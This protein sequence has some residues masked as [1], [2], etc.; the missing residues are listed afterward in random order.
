ML[1]QRISF[2]KFC[3]NDFIVPKVFMSAQSRKDFEAI[4]TYNKL[5]KKPIVADPT[6]SQSELKR[7]KNYFERVLEYRKRSEEGFKPSKLFMVWRIASLVNR[8]K[9]EKETIIKLGLVHDKVKY[10]I[11]K[12]TASNNE[13]LWSVKHLI[14][15]K[16]IEFP[17]GFP[18]EDDLYKTYLKQNGE[19]IVEPRL[20]VD[21][22]ELERDAELKK[23]TLD[24]RH[25]Q[26]DLRLMWW[27]G[28]P[29]MY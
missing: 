16:P 25:I 17:D 23:K 18:S 19:L 20:H 1:L 24:H 5:R 10:A 21:C 28:Y 3:R 2:L 12:N 4:M 26:E 8:P 13:I 7:M 27:K 22:E 14:R 9:W 11:V 6:Y 15:V 29:K